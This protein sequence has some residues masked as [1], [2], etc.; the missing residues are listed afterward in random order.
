MWLRK[1]FTFFTN[2]S[3]AMHRFSQD[4]CHFS[5]IQ[6]HQSSEG[7]EGIRTLQN[8]VFLCILILRLSYVEDPL[9]FN[10]ADT[11]NKY[12]ITKIPIVLL[13]R[14]HQKYCM[15]EMLIFCAD[16]VLVM[17]RSGNLHAFNFIIL[18]T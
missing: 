18:K 15:P 10:L 14:F 16:K 13:V 17:G 4:C 6:Q 1:E 12:F 8:T 11:E 3:H 7:N 9:H 5:P 2:Q